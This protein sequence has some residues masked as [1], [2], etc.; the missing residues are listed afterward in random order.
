MRFN[1]ERDRFVDAVGWVTRALPSRP[2]APVL[3]GVLL[4]A[5]DQ[6]VTL[7]TF[8]HETFSAVD[9]AAAGVAPGRVLVSGH[10]LG[11]VART[12]PDHPVD[13]SLHGNR[14]RLNCGP[15]RFHLPLMPVED[16]PAPPRL[17]PAVGS[18]DA[19]EFADAV[20]QV[21]AAAGRD[22]M[23]P[24]LTGIRL[25]LSGADLVLSATDRYRLAERRV[26]WTPV[27]EGVAPSHPD[28]VLVPARMLTET[29]RALA[30]RAEAT[31]CLPAD[32]SAPEGILGIHAGARR[33][34]TRLLQA[35]FPPIEALWPTVFPAVADVPV[36]ELAEAINRVCLVAG[37]NPP[38]LLSFDHDVV[39]VSAGEP[40]E[41]DAEQDVAVTFTGDPITLAFT[42]P[43]LLDG[44]RSVGTDV[45][46]LSLTAVGKPVLVTAVPAGPDD[47]VAFRY[48]TMSLRR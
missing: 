23:L 34:A 4:D 24:M 19:D 46:R 25:D 10:L 36:R 16:R 22:D 32:P 12:L 8:D 18:V 3:A 29:A 17:P 48:L 11:P 15:V 37:S 7:S 47:P 13:L 2:A 21:S 38:V 5:R 41:A 30:G 44:L 14:V 27:Q 1:V 9:C 6:R 28:P 45:V 43:Y 35:R 33:T 40:D 31:V 39:R 20:A 26:A 42:P